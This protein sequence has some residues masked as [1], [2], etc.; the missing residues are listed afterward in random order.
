M[1]AGTPST[2]TREQVRAELLQAQRAGLI[3]NGDTAVERVLYAD[4]K[5]TRSR[6]EVRAEAVQA[7]RDGALTLAAWGR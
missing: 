5:S 6:A 3:V 4:F 2:L 1:L 7:R